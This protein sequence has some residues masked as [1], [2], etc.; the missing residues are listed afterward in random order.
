LLQQTNQMNQPAPT[1]H[2]PEQIPS[3]NVT[4]KRKS[5]FTDRPVEEEEGADPQK[6]Y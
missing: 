6:K 5:R 1:S 2:T 4:V 3:Q